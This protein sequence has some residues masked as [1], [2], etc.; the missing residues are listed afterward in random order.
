M[1]DKT[2]RNGKVMKKENRKRINKCVGRI[3]IA[4]VVAVMI[5]C[6]GCSSTEETTESGHTEETAGSDHTG[7]SADT[8]ETN[9]TS[10]EETTSQNEVTE[11]VDPKPEPAEPELEGIEAVVA[12]ART[13][14]CSEDNC[15][16]YYDSTTKQGTVLEDGQEISPKV[17]DYILAIGL[18]F[19]GLYCSPGSTPEYYNFDHYSEDHCM[20]FS[21][22][23]EFVNADDPIAGILNDDGSYTRYEFTVANQANEENKETI[24]TTY[25]DFLRTTD[26]TEACVVVIDMDYILKNII[27]E[28]G[29]SYT[30]AEDEILYLYL[31]KEATS[32]ST[33]TENAEIFD[34]GTYDDGLTYIFLYVSSGTN[35]EIPISIEY[36]DGTTEELTIYITR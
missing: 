7:A 13:L 18:T 30:L 12:Y 3:L 8:A 10:A 25:S 29:D 36:A 9:T 2:K 4:A 33:T 23:E 35:M 26:R 5:L 21:I 28:D 34:N 15:L 27:L 17:G 1:M 32:F 24:P 6:M 20:I 31:P 16:I 11:P 22:N 19:K 14:E